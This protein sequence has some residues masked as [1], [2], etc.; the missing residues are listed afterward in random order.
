MEVQFCQACSQLVSPHYVYCPQCGA[1]IRE[2]LDFQTVL[3]QSLAPLEKRE[4]QKSVAR[5]EELIGRLALLDEG[6]ELYLSASRKG[7]DAEQSVR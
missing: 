3:D 6:L 4:R 7:K 2:S 5:L 1:R